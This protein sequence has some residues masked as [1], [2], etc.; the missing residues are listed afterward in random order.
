MDQRRE[1]EASL[2]TLLLY[3]PGPKVFN[4]DQS[5]LQVTLDLNH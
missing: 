4:R 3:K 1:A 5:C 2:Q